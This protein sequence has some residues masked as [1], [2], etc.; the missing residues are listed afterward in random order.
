M[1]GRYMR[2]L[3][4]AEYVDAVAGQLEREG[5]AE[6]AADRERLERA[7]AIAQEKAQTLSE[8]WP[9]IGFLFEPPVD[10][11]K[12]WGKVMGDGVA[13]RL[14]AA[15]EA[16]RA[17]DPFEPEPL[18]ASL[19]AIVERLEIKA[20]DLYQPIRVA[21]TGTT[22]SPGIFD[23]LAALGREES[24]ARVERALTRARG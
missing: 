3:E 21:I 10:D 6:A 5:H 11:P 14:E 8:V 7:C 9:L 17:T 12:A 24:C 15:L 13:P 1:N 16:M 22:V 2:E 23:S 4:P 20:R 19:G 18:E